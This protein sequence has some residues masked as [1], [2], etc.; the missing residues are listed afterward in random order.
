[1]ATNFPTSLDNSTSLPYP[2]SGN[3]TNAPSLAG[4]N[5]NQNDALIATQ[6]K[7][8]IGASTPT[9]GK[10]LT[11]TGIGTSAW[12]NTVPAGTV[13]GTSD[14]QTLTNKTLTSPTISSPVITNATIST[15]LITGYTTSNTGTVYGIPITTGVI[16][17][18][19]TING[20]SL[21]A[22]SVT[23]SALAANS[24]TNT[25]ITAGNL[26][27]S[28][29]YNPY[30]FG[31]YLS[32]AQNSINGFVKVNL[33]VKEYD[34]SNNFDNTTNFRFTAPIAGFYQFNWAV[35]M[36]SAAAAVWQ[37]CLYKGLSGGSS[38]IYKY[39]SL[40]NLSSSYQQ[41]VGTGLVQLAVG[42]FVELWIYASAVI[43]L[44][45]SQPGT[46]L[47]GYLVSAT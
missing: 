37:A 29:F 32:T 18:A 2:S 3:F 11:G 34:T 47:E 44:G 15:D 40:I 31:Y 8:G 10:F 19:G 41:S 46:F 26:Y 13:V 9:S 42:D 25:A 30:K 43:A 23:S 7:L 22:S 6:T 5:D 1:M 16:N 36:S 24:V 17:T 35:G 27:A 39:G 21:V 20:A 4:L 14:S 33:N 28:K 38:S 45:P 12:S